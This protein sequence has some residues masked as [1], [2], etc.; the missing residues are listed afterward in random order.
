MVPVGDEVVTFGPIQRGQME[1]EHIRNR[2][3]PVGPNDA[4]ALSERPD[5]RHLRAVTNGFQHHA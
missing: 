1:R 2:V 3:I 4:Q 5:S